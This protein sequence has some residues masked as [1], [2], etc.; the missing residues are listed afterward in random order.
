[1]AKI[2]QFERYQKEKPQFFEKIA[3]LEKKHAISILPKMRERRFD[4]D[5]FIGLMAEVDFGLFL[6]TFCERLIFEPKIDGLTPDWLV[7]IEGREVIVEVARLKDT[8][9]VVQQTK[10]YEESGNIVIHGLRMRPERVFGNIIT[11]KLQKYGKLV[12]NGGYP[13]IIGVYNRHLSGAHS[14]D[15]GVLFHG[16]IIEDQIFQKKDID[17]ETVKKFMTELNLM[18][19][20]VSGI[21]WLDQPSLNIATWKRDEN[22]FVFWDNERA[23]HPIGEVSSLQTIRGKL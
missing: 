16:S 15:A 9:E 2:D 7:T 20:L 19:R 22:S 3:A 10:R 1:M 18:R 21:L 8:D 14:E 6:D 17:P 11:A 4:F 13:F 5:S 23:I 12:Q